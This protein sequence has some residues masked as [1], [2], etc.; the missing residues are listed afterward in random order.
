VL[1]LATQTVP[2]AAITNQA[3]VPITDQNDNPL[4]TS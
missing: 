3:G 4:T 1:A 2:A